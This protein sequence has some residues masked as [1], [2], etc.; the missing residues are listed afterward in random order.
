MNVIPQSIGNRTIVAT[1]QGR[2]VETLQ[3]GQ[4]GT[5]TVYAHTYGRK[6]FK[7]SKPTQNHFVMCSG[8][9]DFVQGWWNKRVGA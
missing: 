7:S 8:P 6:T 5:A 3:I 9:V 2:W 1:H 4:H